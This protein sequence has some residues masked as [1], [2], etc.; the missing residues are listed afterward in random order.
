VKK[1]DPVIADQIRHILLLCRSR[2]TDPVTV[3]DAGGFL[4][5]PAI[6]DRDAVNLLDDGIIPGI[7]A[8]RVPTDVKTPLDMKLMII[9]ALE[10]FRD[11]LEAAQ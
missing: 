9:S 3:L 1:I 2:G 4:R 8:M 6:R 10:G 5:H 11:K 7:K